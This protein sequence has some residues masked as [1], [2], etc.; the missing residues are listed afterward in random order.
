MFGAFLMDTSTINALTSII[1]APQQL[2]TVCRSDAVFLGVLAHGQVLV[3]KGL[4][5]EL[6]LPTR[7]IAS[8]FAMFRL[9]GRTVPAFYGQLH[10]FFMDI[11]QARR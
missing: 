11:L 8:R 4:L 3:E 6:N 10:S 1:S 5:V 7:G 2:E 9:A